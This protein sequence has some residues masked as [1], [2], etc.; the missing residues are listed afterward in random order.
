MAADSLPNIVLIITDQQRADT[1]GVLGAPH[2]ETPVLDGLAAEGIAFTH[3]FT[4]APACVPARAGLF[5]GYYGHNNNVLSNSDRWVPTWVEWLADRG[6]H[7]VSVGKMRT[8][9]LDAPGGFHQRFIVENKDR[10]LHLEDH[11]AAFYDEWDKHLAHLGLVKPSRETYRSYSGYEGALG[12]YDWPLEGRLHPD[13]FVGN[14][15]VWWLRQ[16]RS[17]S[18]LFLQVGFPGP[19]PPFDPVAEYAER[20]L[21]KELP[22][23]EIREEEMERQ[24]LPQKLLREE[25]ISVTERTG[26]GHDAIFWRR[27]PE[28][29]Q[30]HRMRAYYYANVTMIDHQVGR[31]LEALREKGYLDNCLLF[32]TSDHGDALGEHGLIEKWSMYDHTVRVPLVLWGSRQAL[33]GRRGGGQAAGGHSCPPGLRLDSLVQLFDLA[34]T[35]LEAAGIRPPED[36]DAASLWPLVDGREQE[37]R[38]HVFSETGEDWR[39][40]M[41]KGSSL[42]TMVRSRDWKLVHYLGQDFGELYDLREDPQEQ[43]NL[44]DDGRHRERRR[45]LLEVLCRWRMESQY[46][47]APTVLP[48]GSG[49]VARSPAGPRLGSLRESR[50]GH[51]PLLDNQMGL[52]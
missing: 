12:A 23:P 32:F 15:A 31:L 8:G 4:T 24:V 28:R 39:E 49:R 43:N 47:G 6:Y 46:H 19:H 21:G 2:M 26:T 17:R 48:S 35:I 33:E 41:F 36:W 11:A 22:V 5:T 1:I 9:P 45:R 13:F 3:C 20:Y 30:L 40:G 44:W 29:Q 42:M 25:M 27:V 52:G 16:R 50:R 34:P 14:M 10:P 18:P 38:R 37:G 7:C 51:P